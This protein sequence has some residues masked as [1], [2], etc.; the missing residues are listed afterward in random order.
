MK[1]S[2]GSFIIFF[3]YWATK[4]V[5]GARTDLRTLLSTTNP[6]S[7]KIAPIIASKTSPNIFGAL[8]GSIYAWLI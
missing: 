1:S 5:K 8:N 7:T 2:L 6:P 3:E 4:I